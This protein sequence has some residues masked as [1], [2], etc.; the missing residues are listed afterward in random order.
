M[1][2]NHTKINLNIDRPV[3]RLNGAQVVDEMHGTKA[4]SPELK[5]IQLQQLN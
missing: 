2:S 5:M 3:L 1:E 4:E